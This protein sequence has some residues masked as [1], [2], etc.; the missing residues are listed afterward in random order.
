MRGRKPKPSRLKNPRV[1]HRRGNDS[2]PQPRPGAE[3]P[4]W[5]DDVAR[6]EWRRIAEE[7]HRLHLLTTLDQSTLSGYC[8]AYSKWRE[9]EEFLRTN[10]TTFTTRSDKGIVV[11]TGP[12]PQ[13]GIALKMAAMVRAF[14]GDLGFSP[15]SRGRLQL[16]QTDPLEDLTPEQ[17]GDYLAE[18]ENRIAQL[19]STEEAE[20]QAVVQ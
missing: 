19:E 17:K 18:I 1:T 13:V 9:A 20:S 15:S 8:W 4:P 5:L 16:P 3:C 7:L 11:A 10:G 14:G 12:V 6:E 2:E